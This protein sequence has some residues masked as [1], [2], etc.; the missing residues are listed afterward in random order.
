MTCQI[1]FTRIKMGIPY[2]LAFLLREP[3]KAIQLTG[4]DDETPFVPQRAGHRHAILP[5]PS[6]PHPT[7]GTTLQYRSTSPLRRG[8][9]QR[10]VQGFCGACVSWLNGA[11]LWRRRQGRSLAVCKGIIKFFVNIAVIKRKFVSKFHKADQQPGFAFFITDCLG[12]I[13]AVFR[14]SKEYRRV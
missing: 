3:G 1:F 10:S 6:P 4:E 2:L 12:I 7:R 13:F 14:L 8:D 9:V 11:K 5:V